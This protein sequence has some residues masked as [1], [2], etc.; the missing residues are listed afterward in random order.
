MDW[1]NIVL[2]FITLLI[3]LTFHEAAH[4]TFA[5]LGGDKTAYYGGQVSLNPVPHIQREPFG[6]VV[7]PLL[8]LLMSNGTMCMGYAKT[9]VDP[10]WAQRNPRKAAL[11]SAAGPMANLLLA[12]VAFAVLYFVD[13][14]DSDRNFHI[15]RV[16]DAFLKLNLLL[17][18]LNL[19]PLPPLDGFGVV[20]G[21]IPA[22]RRLYSQLLRT[23]IASLIVIVLMIKVLPLVFW[24]TYFKVQSWLPY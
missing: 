8:A 23:P 5:L 17:V 24:P 3:S 1:T 16:A 18:L 14:R 12:A 15:H 11:M 9:P 21:L 2:L 20:S 22:S 4:A 7:L 13:P 19:L 10:Y 6:T